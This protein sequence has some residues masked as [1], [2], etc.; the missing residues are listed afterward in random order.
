MQDFEDAPS[1]AAAS[2]PAAALTRRDP[3]LDAALGLILPWLKVK[4]AAAFS[5][6]CQYLMTIKR[7]SAKDSSE[8]ISSKQLA[9]AVKQ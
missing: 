8:T 9:A 7:P 4:A 2:C 3:V 6:K 5:L 1:M